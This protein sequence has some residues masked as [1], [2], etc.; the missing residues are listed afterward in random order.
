M[1][2]GIYI[3]YN[4]NCEKRFREKG[5]RNLT[6]QMIHYTKG[7][8]KIQGELVGSMNPVTLVGGILSEVKVLF[9][10]RVKLAENVYVWDWKPALVFCCD[11]WSL[12][13]SMIIEWLE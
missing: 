10:F 9:I 1:L 4:M 6:G 5:L 11:F 7:A 12:F 3:E 2:I 13:C 8:W